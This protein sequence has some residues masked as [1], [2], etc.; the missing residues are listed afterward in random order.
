MRFRTE[1]E[2]IFLVD[3]AACISDI[4]LNVITCFRSS[5]SNTLRFCI[6]ISGDSVDGIAPIKLPA[7]SEALFIAIVFCYNTL[8][9]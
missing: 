1:I 5:S 9:Q 3:I 7:R 6:L 4:Q 2:S 8:F